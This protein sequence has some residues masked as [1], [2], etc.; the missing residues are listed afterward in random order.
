M[1]NNPLV[2]IIIPIYKVEK[3]LKQGLDSVIAQTYKN[4]EII[5]IDD[6]SPDN[7]G[8]ICDEYAEKDSR[9]RVIHKEN[10]GVSSARNAGIE[11]S[12]GEWIYFMDPD[13]YI[14][15]EMI[16]EM[17]SFA[18]KTQTDMCFCDFDKFRGNQIKL[19]KSLKTDREVFKDMKNLN[20]LVDYMSGMGSC[21]FFIVRSGCLKGKVEYNGDFKIHEDLLCKLSIYGN[22][23]S[24]SYLHKIFYH[25]RVSEKGAYTTQRLANG[26]DE[27]VVRVYEEMIKIMKS[28][29]YPE[30]SDII[31]NSQLINKLSNV[32]DYAFNR[33]D[34]SFWER[35]QIIKKFISSDNLRNAFC[36]YDKKL[37]N[38]A[39]KIYVKF[40]KPQFLV[41]FAVN[42]LKRIVNV[43][44]SF[45]RC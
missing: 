31:A 21:C 20:N 45:A 39:E 2:S 18:K 7:C 13:D 40:R 6:G 3:F 28:Q 35:K 42:T 5:L 17:L 27:F 29:A 25:Y 36:N 12:T 37:L 14:E 15:L 41:V 44:N 8:K 33:K 38:N 34:I 26:Y 22:I 24:F 4:L 30:N 16:E 43:I 19:K 9:I 11:V 23:T 1:K 10:G 32:A